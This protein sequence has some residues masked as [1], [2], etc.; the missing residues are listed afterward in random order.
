MATVGLM[1]TSA[2]RNVTF[3]ALTA[4]LALASGAACHHQS[5]ELGLPGATLMASEAPCP[6]LLLSAV[7]P[8]LGRTKGR[9][10]TLSQQSALPVRGEDL[11]NAA[12]APLRLPP[13]ATA[14]VDTDAP[15]AIVLCATTKRAAPFAVFALPTRDQAAS[16]LLANSLGAKVADRQGAQQVKRA[17]GTTLWLRV[18]ERSV[19]A[20]P[21][22]EGL[23]AGGPSANAIARTTSNDE[24]Q[25][26]TNLDAL[27]HWQGIS[28]P[29]AIAF[30]K[31]RA[32]RSWDKP[33]PGQPAVTP[34]ARAASRAMLDAIFD[35][36]LS[37]LGDTKTV[38]AT[39]RVLPAAGPEL[40]VALQPRTGSA[41]AAELA[42]RT[43]YQVAPAFLASKD[44]VAITGAMGPSEF[45]PRFM[46]A[47]LAQ[48]VKVGNPDAAAL[49]S[50]MNNWW[51]PNFTG[52]NSVR[53]TF[54]KGHVQAEA[55]QTLRPTANASV[56][57]D[58]LLAYGKA[59]SAFM[60]QG[61]AAV[62]PTKVT[63]EGDFVRTEQSFAKAPGPVDFSAIV[64]TVVGSE[65]LTT[66]ST[67]SSGHLLMATEPGAKARLAELT[68]LNKLGAAGSPPQISPALGEALAATAGQESLVYIDLMTVARALVTLGDLPKA[69][70]QIAS[71]VLSMP[72][73]AQRELPVVFSHEA[74]SRLSVHLRV[75]AATF[76]T[77][78]AVMQMLGG[79]GGALG[80]ALGDSTK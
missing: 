32:L 50:L 48:Q 24:A 7:I 63:R 8:S 14:A 43:P 41:F 51:L 52:A 17:D 71:M 47:L 26:A 29:Q 42:Q 15:I 21:S 66:V 45:F 3:L 1:K 67:V 31:G 58:G 27:L 19:T 70:A 5:R 23:L 33:L 37:R 78:G 62:L 25:V 72:G 20:S 80:G 9:I 61:N 75:P 76:A 11:L 55:V 77:A 53:A 74:G 12:L 59:N 28:A 10:D 6:N 2:S 54:Q 49:R 68:R 40:I 60:Q 56:I 35:Q 13:E 69:Q 73:I 38:E 4:T 30:L 64:K 39:F 36:V 34:A 46:D 16:S 57:L 44:P 65:T 79:L 18:G 22:L